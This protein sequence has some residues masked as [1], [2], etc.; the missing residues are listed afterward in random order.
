MDIGGGIAAPGAP[1]IGAAQVCTLCVKH[2]MAAA[3]GFGG[4]LVV[5]RLESLE[6]FTYRCGSW[7]RG[8]VL[9]YVSSQVAGSGRSS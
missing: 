3:G 5:K 4:E 7:G 8:G 9:M 2:G 6:T 1:G